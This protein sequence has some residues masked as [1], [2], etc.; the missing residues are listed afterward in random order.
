MDS[1]SFDEE[2]SGNKIHEEQPSEMGFAEEN[3]LQA[4]IVTVGSPEVGPVGNVKGTVQHAETHEKR[5]QLYGF[6]RG[7]VATTSKDATTTPTLGSEM[8]TYN[9]NRERKPTRPS[10]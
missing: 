2:L 5:D 9:A 7:S 3:H 6:T 1:H 8:Y 4:E 10:A